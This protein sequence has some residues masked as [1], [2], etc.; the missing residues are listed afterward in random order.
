LGPAEQLRA[1]HEA[2]PTGYVLYWQLTA[3]GVQCDAVVPTLEKI[4]P[5][6][7]GG[8]YSIPLVENAFDGGFMRSA[9]KTVCFFALALF[10][11]PLKSF[12]AEA[13]SDSTSLPNPYRTIE[14]WAKPPEG[15]PLGG[16]SAVSLDRKG[17]LWVFQRCGANTCAGSTEDP[18]MEF[19]SSGHF[20]KSFGAGLI[21]FPHALFIDSDGNI[22]VTD[23]DGKD[24]KGQQVIKFSPDG[25]VLMTLGKAGVAG[26]GPDTFNKPSGVVVARNGDIFVADGHGANSNARIVKFSKD[27]KFLKSWGERGTGPMEFGELHAIT[28]DAKGRVF[29]AD[30]GNNRISIFDQNGNLIDHW[31]QFGRPSGIFIDRK[32]KIYVPDNTDTRPDWQ[33]G[34]RIGTLKD[35]KVT[36]FIPDPDQDLAHRDFGAENLFVNAKGEIFGAQVFRKTVTKYVP[37]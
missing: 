32:G 35:G 19:D 36:A 17:N 31:T 7:G 15:H 30:R 22:W 9:G 1:C 23:A 26:D 25:K 29:V 27:G 14:N 10:L 33:R 6:G 13:A 21:V 8:H 18:I 4:N 20:I 5:T 28:L 12:A 24:G 2:G 34:I 3:M 11:L 16:V 37:Q